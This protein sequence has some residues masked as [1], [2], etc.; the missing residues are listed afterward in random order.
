MKNLCL[1]FN[2]PTYYNEPTY[3]LLEKEY[4]C[5]WYFGDWV[6]DIKKMDT[7]QFKECHILKVNHQKSKLFTQKGLITILR[8]KENNTFLMTGETRNL[9]FWW[10]LFVR[11]LFY[12]RKRIYLWTHGWYGKES[13]IEAII[14]K[15]M[16][17]SVTGIFTYG[18][19]AKNLMAKEGI[20]EAK[21]FP[22]HNALHY[23]EQKELRDRISKTDIYFNHFGSTNPILLF[24]G[25]LTKVKKLDMLLRTVAS[26]NN[27]CRPCN[28]VLVGD[29]EEKEKLIK[30]AS[31]L[32]ISDKVWFYGECYKEDTNAELIYNADICVAPGN[33]G[34][35]AMHS[36]MFGTPVITHDNFA[37][38]MPEF[39]A[40]KEECTGAFYHH[41]SQQSLDE[42]VLSWLQKHDDDRET[43]RKNCF[44]EID[45]NW[46][47]YFQ[48]G[49]IKRNIKTG[50]K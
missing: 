42:V 10:F 19:Y 11:N 15:W 12:R 43:I 29:G 13:K 37:Y 20:S 50:N 38:Q 2:I 39:E 18:E 14:K 9:S 47:P 17:R 24:I 6:T 30:L 48:I 16:F 32:Q 44:K 41:G 25:R 40:I 8:D 5:K 7:S 26:L 21:I 35:T 3:L 31:E 22:I 49:V 36:L 4:N 1:V 28:L 45:D 23:K 34:L 27:S 46:T 33:V